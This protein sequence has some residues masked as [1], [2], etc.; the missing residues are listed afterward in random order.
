MILN[1][2]IVGFLFAIT[3]TIKSN[4]LLHKIQKEEVI[5]YSNIISTLFIFLFN[6]SIMLKKDIVY[7]Y[8]LL[9]LLVALSVISYTY[10]NILAD[11]FKNFDSSQVMILI[12][13]FETIFLFLLSNSKIT[14]KKVLS[15]LFIIAGTFLYL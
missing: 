15:V 13:C 14:I 6:K 10:N 5:L 3:P 12:K 9:I 7:N 2:F 1:S 8:K 4:I 11:L